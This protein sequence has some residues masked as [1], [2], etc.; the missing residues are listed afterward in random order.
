MGEL[1]DGGATTRCE[2]LCN[3]ERELVDSN[4]C[5]LPGLV[6]DDFLFD[7]IFPAR[8]AGRLKNT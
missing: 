8:K 6:G 2:P 5:A 3:R 7:H 1:S 4:F